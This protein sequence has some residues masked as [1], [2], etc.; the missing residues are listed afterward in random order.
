MFSV[1]FLIIPN[2]WLDFSLLL[3]TEMTCLI[4]AL[5]I[6]FLSSK[7]AL[8]S[9]FYTWN[10]D[11]SSLCAVFY[12]SLLNFTYTLIPPSLKLRS[13]FCTSWQSVLTIV[14]NN[15]RLSVNFLLTSLSRS[16]LN[17]LNNTDPT[18]HLQYIPLLIFLVVEDMIIYFYFGYFKF[19]STSHSSIYCFTFLW[20]AEVEMRKYR[21]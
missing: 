21:Q 11:Y 2:I 15:F 10:Q 19:S 17:M 4:L 5:K 12:L 14:I 9:Y 18:T 3:R 7:S 8:P 6:L 16:F 13:H 1:S 20:Y